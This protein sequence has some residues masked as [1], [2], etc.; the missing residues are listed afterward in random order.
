MS[1]IIDI[2][3]KLNFDEKP[4]F[5]VKDIEIEA[6]NDAVTMLKVAA[7]FEND[8]IK[9]SDILDAY[10]LLFDE[11][12][13]RKVNSLK[14][15]IKDFSTFVMHTAERLINNGEEPEGETKTPAMT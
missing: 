12:N 7:I 15:N 1:K 14:L 8:K 5:K 11:E 10:N 2:T 6:N 4:I 13:Q 9:M 3:N